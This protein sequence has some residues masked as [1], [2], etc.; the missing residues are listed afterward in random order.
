MTSTRLTRRQLLRQSAAG[1]LA[2]GLWPGALRARDADQP[3]EFHFLVINDLH[4]QN[5]RCGPWFER[6]I[7]QIKALPNSI[8]LCLLVGDLA[9]HGKAEQ[10]APIRDLFEGLKMLV[11]VVVGN[12]DYL[13]HDD[14]KSYE[15]LFPRSLNYHFEHRGWQFV[16]LDS[17][18]GRRPVVAVQEPTL[19]WL[20][21]T[22]PK[23]EKKRPTVVFTHFPLGQS[24][25]CR[26]TNAEYVL[27]RFKEFNLQAVYNGH[28]HAFTERKV[29]QTTL[30]TNR[31]C[32]FSKAN[33]DGS[34]EKGFFLCHAK[35]GK[36]ERR[37]IEA[38]PARNC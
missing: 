13:T 9:E 1:L 16:G 4:Y 24:V 37:F 8:D 38:K 11:H 14:R 36:I 2:A 7:G 35:D 31:C 30:T 28:Y 27:A 32:A 15:E 12:H 29:G 25:V 6:L 23:L 17:S 20:A 26:A 3:G 18:Y 22:L 10:L 21:D 5:E 34:K 33:H 19:R